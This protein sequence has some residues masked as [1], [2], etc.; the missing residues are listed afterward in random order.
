MQDGEYKAV[1][2][3]TVPKTEGIA[4]AMRYCEENQIFALKL[5]SEKCT[6]TADELRS[7]F[8]GVG[9]HAYLSE[10]TDVIYVGNG[11]LALH[12]S[13]AGVKTITL[14]EQ[15]KIKPA[16]EGTAPLLASSL[17]F[18]AEQFETK[19]FEISK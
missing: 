4:D 15:V 13:E 19:I 11:I 9:L 16:H 3:A 17:T 6:Y 18:N 14:P 8:K 5:T 2:F 12:A 10:G 7:V 1:L